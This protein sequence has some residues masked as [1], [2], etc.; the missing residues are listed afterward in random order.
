LSKRFKFYP[1]KTQRAI[2]ELCSLLQSDN[3][4]DVQK[5]LSE[6]S[7]RTGFACLFS[8]GPG[9]GKTET[10]IQI[11][12]I[13]GRDIMQVD[14]AAT[15]SKW[16]GESEKQIKS[17][18]DKYRS[19]VKKCAITPI[20][21]FN[22]ADAVFGK[23]RILNETRNGPDQTE[24]AIQNVILREIENLNGILIATTNLSTNMDAA[25][26]RRFL[27][28]FEFDRPEATTRKSIW[29]SLINGLSDEDAWALASRFDFSGGQ[30]ENI[31][32]KST[33]HRVLSGR[34][35]ILEDMVKFCSGECSVK[36]KRI[37]FTA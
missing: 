8:G 35:P 26:E 34:T 13:T 32:R 17:I 14:I 20:L 22:E 10:A 29:T 3:F 5:R 28:K 37:G 21:L 7:M 24:N 33:V 31:A 23:R 36:D 15:K 16:F 4:L 30:I 1:D 25:F 27:Y 9:T 19:C 6:N 2:N 11:A 12:R 18:F